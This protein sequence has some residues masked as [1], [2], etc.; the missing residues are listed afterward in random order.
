MIVEDEFVVACDLCDTLEALGYSVVAVVGTG[1]EA[2]TTAAS[3]RPT[4]ILMDIR[5]AGNMDGIQAAARIRSEHDIPIVFLSAHSNEDTLQRATATE[6]FG[7]LVK[8]FKGAELRCALEVAIRNHRSQRRQVEDQARR[9]ADDLE[10]RAAQ[11]TMELETANQELEAFSISP[12]CSA[13][14]AA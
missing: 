13:R 9:L 1:E 2:V 7:Y 8:P 4:A 6:P 12:P 11:R 5:L 14:R 3:V 10:R